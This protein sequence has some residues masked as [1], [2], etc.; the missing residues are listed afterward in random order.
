MKAEGNLVG[1]KPASQK[2][3]ERLFERHTGATEFVETSLAVA[4][5]DASVAAGR[6]VAVLADRAGRI[7]HV[8][9]GD[10]ASV[11]LPGS[12]RKRV[13]AGRLNGFRLIVST[14]GTGLDQADLEMMRLFSFDAAV[15]VVNGRPGTTPLVQPAWPLPPGAGMWEVLE[16]SYPGRFVRTFDETVRDLEVQLRRAAADNLGVRGSVKATDAAIVVIPSFDRDADLD[17]DRSEMVA[18]CSTAG[19]AVIETV[20]QKRSAPDPKFV[21]GAGKLR[22]IAMMCLNRAADLIIFG[23]TLSPSQQRNIAAVAGVRV[24]DRNQLI[25]DIFAKHA[26]SVEGR[27][28]VE[29]AQLR[30]NL[31]RLSERDDAMSRLSGGIGALGPGETKLEMERRRARDRIH[32]LEQKIADEAARR[33]LRRQRRQ[34]NRVSIVAV[35]GYTNAGKSTLFNTLTGADVP[36]R[37]K[38]FA[39]LDP[40]VRSLKMPSGYDVLL[41]DTVGFI[42]DLPEELEG[43]FRAT[44]EEMSGAAVLL[45]VADASDPHVVVQVESVRH[46]VG[47]MGYGQIPGV[48]ALNKTDRLRD[49]GALESLVRE[50]GGIPVCAL[51][52][53]TLSPLIDQI[54]ACIENR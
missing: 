31:P 42:R 12:L 21:T 37:D 33:L 23:V 11:E 8:V 3:I 51:D 10:G 47:Q 27:L 46:I 5:Q 7:C 35:V 9:V 4:L 41:V 50:T 39:T 16:T 1:L 43:A 36:A 28:E 32:L 24:I 45:Q 40:T 44:L 13:P 29:L 48:L 52:R 25:L 34:L 17:W 15:A 2:Q 19:I 49:R 18:L 53:N 14:F 26:G 22:E 6:R 54:A 20:V 30:Y 38:L